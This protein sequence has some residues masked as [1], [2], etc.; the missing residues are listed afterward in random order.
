MVLKNVFTVRRGKIT[1]LCI[2][3]MTTRFAAR[4][5]KKTLRLWVSGKKRKGT[6]VWKVEAE[7]WKC[8][9]DWKR[10]VTPAA[11]Q[12]NTSTKT[13]S[14]RTPWPK[15]RWRWWV[16][17]LVVAPSRYPL[18]PLGPPN[19]TAWHPSPPHLPE[20]PFYLTSSTSLL[21]KSLPLH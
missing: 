21:R 13:A 17:H 14:P 18:D 15:K 4:R 6:N 8:A 11:H 3:Q 12:T 16:L 19:T 10:S 9:T 1:N 5:R 7:R 2:W 20:N